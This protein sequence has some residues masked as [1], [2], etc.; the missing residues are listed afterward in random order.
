MQQRID[1]RP[2]FDDVVAEIRLGGGNR[3]GEAGR[4]GPDN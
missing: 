4:A 2:F 3:R 1:Q